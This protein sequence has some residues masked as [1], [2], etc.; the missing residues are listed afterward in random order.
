MAFPN[1]LVLAEKNSQKD[2]N[3]IF[4]SGQEEQQMRVQSELARKADSSQELK[5]SIYHS[6]T[7]IYVV[8]H[9]QPDTEIIVVNLNSRQTV[10]R[11]FVGW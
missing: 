8:V 1:L 10:V 2:V 6:N 5:Y 9:R 7:Y 3:L 11:G 4:F